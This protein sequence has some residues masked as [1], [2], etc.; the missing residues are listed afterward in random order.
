M[1]SS[2]DPTAVARILYKE[3]VPG[4]LRKFEAKSNDTPSGGGARDLRFGDYASM[5]PMIA[6]MFPKPVPLTRRRKNQ[7]TKVQGQ[8]GLLFWQTNQGVQSKEIIF[9]PPT[10]ARKTEGRIA[11][12]HLQPALDPTPILPLKENDKVFLV[13]A[14]RNDGQV[15]PFFTTESSL[16]TPGAWDERVAT[17]ILTCSERKRARGVVV[18]GYR[19]FTTAEGYC[20]GR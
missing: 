11:R 14:Q 5:A 13:F 15:W 8:S 1:P 20:N 17:E 6:K 2:K 9:E 18:I 7:T 4:D 10:T 19:D 16:R 12:V 3:I